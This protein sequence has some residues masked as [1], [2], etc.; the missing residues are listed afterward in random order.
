MTALLDHLIAF[1]NNG[2]IGDE[3]HFERVNEGANGI[4]YKTTR[5]SGEQFAVKIARKSGRNRA[6]REFQMSQAIH[7]AGIHDICPQPVRLFQDVQMLDADVVI[8]TWIHGKLLCMPP[9]PESRAWLAILD[10]LQ[11]LHQIPSNTFKM[12]LPPAATSVKHPIDMLSI[13]Q[14][15]FERLPDTIIGY[16][17]YQQIS[18]VVHALFEQVP[19]H[20]SSDAP[21]SLIHGDCHTANMIKT[22]TGIVLVDWE[23]S[24]ISD[25][26]FDLSNMTTLW[27]FFDL[28]ESHHEWLIKEY[29]M[30]LQDR[31]IIERTKVYRI[32]Q[33]VHWVVTYSN[34]IHARAHMSP[35]Q[36]AKLRFSLEFQLTW[37]K[38]YY[39]RACH[40]L[41]IKN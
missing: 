6:W 19:Q 11:R 26:A 4:I 29:A 18:S 10:T 17:T 30:R 31:G 2:L 35:E 28:P 3:Y 25:P 1:H 8:S 40:L 37:Q 13:V 27:R 34:F 7:D 14:N 41:C 22:E 23:N 36:E 33:I 16:L 38:A 12:D 32:I 5:K 9:E 21:Q 15:R 20:W 24:G 39:D